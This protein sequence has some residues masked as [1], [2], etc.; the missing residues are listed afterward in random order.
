MKKICCAG[1]RLVLLLVVMTLI[2]SGIAGA[3]A[4]TTLHVIGSFYDLPQEMQWYKDWVKL[5][6][7]DE[8]KVN[9]S[10]FPTYE[11]TEDMIKALEAQKGKYS[12]MIM[13]SA[14]AD[15]EQV[16][17]SGLLAD[18]SG[19]ELLTSYVG[20]MYP[21]FQEM[22][23]KD[24]KLTGIPYDA[25]VDASGLFCN[26]EC[27]EKA[28]YG[29][30]D[31]PTCFLDLLD[32]L[33]KWA[34][35]NKKEPT[36]ISLMQTYLFVNFARDSYTDWLSRFYVAQYVNQCLRQGEKSVFNTPEAIAVLKRIARIGEA[37]YECDCEDAPHPK[38]QWDT[39]GEYGFHTSW[40]LDDGISSNAPQYNIPCRVTADAPEIYPLRVEVL[41]IPQNAPKQEQAL[42]FANFYIQRIND[43]VSSDDMS[44]ETRDYL[45]CKSR[46]LTDAATSEAYRE[47]ASHMEYSHWN[48]EIPYAQKIQEAIRRFAAGS[49]SAEELVVTIDESITA[50]LGK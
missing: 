4:K 20:R 48:Y 36:G 46:L 17:D 49:I 21:A 24:G 30:E 27:W 1:K 33:E 19:S 40:L 5:H 29:T 2:L 34:E 22:V 6:P 37:L 13:N 44:Y 45:D 8:L 9:T 16:R 23:Y 15:W 41:C 39:E 47:M 42:E 3:Q 50:D 7:K 32:F 14:Y 43:A 12:V 26:Q 10:I 28:G 25:V 31:V 35:R 38:I 18:L 11:T